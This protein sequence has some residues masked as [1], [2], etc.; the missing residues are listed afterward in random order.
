MR[1]MAANIFCTDQCM[2]HLTAAGPLFGSCA[3]PGRVML[4][5]EAE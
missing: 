5:I 1:L 3:E 2:N 4:A